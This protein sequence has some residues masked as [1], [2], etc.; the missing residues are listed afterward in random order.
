MTLAGLIYRRSIL[1]FIILKS[2]MYKNYGGH[3]ESRPRF[4]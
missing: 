4:F 3:L 2:Y 1:T